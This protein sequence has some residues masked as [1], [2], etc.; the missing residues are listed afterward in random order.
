MEHYKVEGYSNLLRDSE[1]GAI[2]NT[3]DV[4]YEQY[5]ATRSLKELES[6]KINSLETEVKD[7]KNDLNEIKYLLRSLVK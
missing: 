4:E 3:N 2:I 6:E 1:V 5:L 7:I